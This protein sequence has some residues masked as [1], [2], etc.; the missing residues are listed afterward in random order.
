[1]GDTNEV[2][3]KKNNPIVDNIAMLTEP[4]NFQ[5]YILGT[6]K[7]GQPRALYDV[8]RD[9][10][11]PKKDKKKKKKHKNDSSIYSLYVTGGKKKKK[12]KKKNKYW[13]I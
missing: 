10:T 9:Y 8:V 1:M 12:H 5:K 6:K 3:V 11:V 4:D 2:V 13:H 7:N